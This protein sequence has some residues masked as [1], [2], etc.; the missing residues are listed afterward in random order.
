MTKARFLWRVALLCNLCYV[1][2]IY[3]RMHPSNNYGSFQSTIL[4]MGTILG[5]TLNVIS[6]ALLGWSRSRKKH[7]EDG[8]RWLPLSNAAFFVLQIIDL[9]I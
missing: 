1:L 8:M 6:L 2:S 4:I 9:L 5:F 3:L 7:W